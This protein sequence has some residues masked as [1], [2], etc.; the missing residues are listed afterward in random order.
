ML[1]SGF[2]EYQGCVLWFTGTRLPFALESDDATGIECTLNKL[3]IE[4]GISEQDLLNAVYDGLAY[5]FALASALKK[6]VVAG[7]FRIIM[8]SDIEGEYPSVTV[9]FH[10][11]RSEEK[12]LD[13]DLENYT[14][15]IFVIDLD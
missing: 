9:R 7:P 4:V 15:A 8:G 11:L 12:W 3:H 1:K 2:G 5:S 13:D 10:R 6:S 14:E